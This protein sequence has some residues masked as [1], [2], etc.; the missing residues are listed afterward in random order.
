M[1]YKSGFILALWHVSTK[2]VFSSK[3]RHL[4]CLF[5]ARYPGK[6]KVPTEVIVLIR[7]QLGPTGNYSMNRQFTGIVTN[8]SERFAS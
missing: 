1:I 4:M 8:G 3:Q 7:D 2:Q 5:P 6:H